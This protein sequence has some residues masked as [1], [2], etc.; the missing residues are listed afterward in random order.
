MKTYAFFLI[1]CMSACSALFISACHKEPKESRHGVLIRSI[2]AGGV[3]ASVI[4][5]QVKADSMT[6]GEVAEILEY[7]ILGG[8]QHHN[9]SDRFR[10]FCE[11]KVAQQKVSFDSDGR[12]MTA[13]RFLALVALESKCVI[14]V[15]DLTITFTSK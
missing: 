15:D 9:P 13:L 14:I 4:I 1:L 10:V 7:Q 6:L 11:E 3:L 5:P 12:E 2:S 8:I